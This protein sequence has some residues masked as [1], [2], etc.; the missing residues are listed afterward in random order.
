MGYLAEGVWVGGD[1]N[2]IG[3]KGHEK[4]AEPLGNLVLAKPQW[5]TDR[6]AEPGRYHL[7]ECPGCPLAHRASIVHRTKGLGSV[8]TTS[9]VRPVMGRNGREFGKPSESSIDPVTGK[10][11]LYELYLA[12]D[13]NYSGRASTPVLWDC[14]TASIVSNRTSDIIAILNREFDEFIPPSVDYRPPDLEVEIDTMIAQLYEE[15][16]GAVYRCG[17]AR[18]QDL[19]EHNASILDRGIGKIEATLTEHPYLLGDI[20]TEADLAL[21]ASLVRYNSI[22]IPLFG[23]TQTRIEDSEILTKYIIQLFD[24][25]GVRETFDL[26]LTMEHYFVSHAHINP[27]KVVPRPPK[28]SWHHEGS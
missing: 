13:P 5:S 28:L 7:I 26:R 22:Y 12:T 10:R 18:E 24:I 4:R 6:K 16:I 15:F 27:R 23:C 9:T 2:Q 3:A 19:Y 14:E 25:P 8:I 20:I 21:F 17:F 11:Y 1:Q